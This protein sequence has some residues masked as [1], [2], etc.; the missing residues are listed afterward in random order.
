MKH[1]T[2]GLIFTLSFAGAAF[3]ATPEAVPIV[4]LNGALIATMKAGAAKTDFMTRYN[5]LAPVVEKSLNLP[6]ILQNS[7][8]FQWASI[9]A[10][11]QQAL[12]KVFEQFTVASYVNGFGGYGGQTLDVL[13]DERVVGATKIV[14]TSLN[15][16]GGPA[17]RL[18][19]V[20]TDG[21]AGWQATDVLL[22][23]TISKVAIQSSDFSAEVTNGDASQL[24]AALKSKVT[25]L[26]GGAL[27]P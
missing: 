14:E 24:I 16:P 7:V 10:A 23:G 25:K 3:A 6:V 15:S 13:P 9:P 26:S 19:Y 27:T 20:M 8:G 11:Q 5:A 17:V 12:G 4:A 18:D 1:F 21:A 2:A 22:Q